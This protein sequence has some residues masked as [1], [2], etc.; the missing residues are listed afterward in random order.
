MAIEI[1]S[2]IFVPMGCSTDLR[3]WEE[4]AERIKI[5]QFLHDSHL[6]LSLPHDLCSIFFTIPNK[7]N[8]FVF[9]VH[10]L[11]HHFTALLYFPIQ[12]FIL[13]C[14]V[15][16]SFSKRQSSMGKSIPPKSNMTNSLVLVVVNSCNKTQRLKQI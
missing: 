15:V 5:R 11:L 7:M 1:K 6:S 12:L 16:K 4:C 2:N 8:V 9:N 10:G 13:V 3:I 14:N